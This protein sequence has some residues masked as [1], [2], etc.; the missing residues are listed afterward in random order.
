MRSGT[1][2]QADAQLQ[3]AVLAALGAD[4]DVASTDIGVGV[5]DGVVSLT[6]EVDSLL[7]RTRARRAA[8]GVPGVRSVANDITVRLSQDHRRTDLDIADD[9]LSALEAD[10]EVP[11]KKIKPRVQDGWIWL[12]GEAEDERQRRA[13][14]RAVEGIAGAK[15]VTNVVRLKP[16]RA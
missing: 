14:E 8:E 4:G 10:V 1:Q 2:L 7:K 15:G 3:S 5:R 6:G 11:D 16:S 12:V 9:A 13:A